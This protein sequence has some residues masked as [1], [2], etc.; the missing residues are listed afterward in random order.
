MGRCR[1]KSNLAVHH[2]CIDE[3]NKIDNAEVLCPI[4]H[5][6]TGSFGQPGH[7]SPPDFDEDVKNMALRNAKYRCECTR[8]QCKHH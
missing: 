1:I 3:G 6:N 2:K 8:P 5:F 7:K 4:C